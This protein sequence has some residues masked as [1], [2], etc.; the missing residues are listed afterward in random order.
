MPGGP[1]VTAF[2]PSGRDAVLMLDGKLLNFDGIRVLLYDPV[3][4]N[5]TV[6][7]SP[8]PISGISGPTLIMLQDGRVLITSGDYFDLFDPNGVI[9]GPSS[10][11][12]GS[13]ELSWWLTVLAA[14]MIVLVGAQYAWSRRQQRAT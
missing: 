11:L 3:G 8:P 5:W 12:I 14:L 13:P 1:S 4:N 9:V 6:A 2:G 7:P 10:A